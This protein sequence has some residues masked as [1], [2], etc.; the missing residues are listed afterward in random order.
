MQ[1]N[2][3]T[4]TKGIDREQKNGF[5]EGDNVVPQGGHINEN[6]EPVEE[7]SDK[8][9]KQTEENNKREPEVNPPLNPPQKTETDTNPWK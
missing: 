8:I 5:I 3:K 6:E 2:K 1:T 7:K 4:G 9:D